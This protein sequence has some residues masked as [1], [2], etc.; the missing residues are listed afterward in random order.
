MGG[1]KEGEY[2]FMIFLIFFV[3]LLLFTRSRMAS[4][5]LCNNITRLGGATCH[6]GFKDSTPTVRDEAVFI[7]FFFCLSIRRIHT[8]T[9]TQ[10]THTRAHVHADL[11]MYI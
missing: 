10:Y 3:K 9:D 1:G 4:S 6:V 8:Y 2:S 7:I 5:I 11:Y